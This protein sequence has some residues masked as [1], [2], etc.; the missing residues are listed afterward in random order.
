MKETN[1]YDPVDKNKKK[2][3]IVFDDSIA[4]NRLVSILKD[5]VRKVYYDE[6]Y[7]LK[8]QAEKLAF[9][10]QVNKEISDRKKKNKKFPL[11]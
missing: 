1:F 2:G 7:H 4:E 3:R 5:P 6:K 10:T 9:E 11:T 8:K